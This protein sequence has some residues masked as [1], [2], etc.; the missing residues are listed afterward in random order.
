[1]VF[2]DVLDSQSFVCTEKVSD[3]IKVASD[4]AVDELIK[5]QTIQSLNLILRNYKSL[6]LASGVTEI[7]AVASAEYSMAKNQ[8]SFFEELFNT[9]GFRFKILTDEEQLNYLYLSFIN[10]LDAPKGLIVSINGT[11]TQLLAY[12]RR[13]IVNQSVI[14]LGTVA[15]A[16]EKFNAGISTE[17]FM[18]TVVN[19]Y[20]SKLK[21]INWFADMDSETQIVGTGDS[22]L[23]LARL[24]Q[25]V[26]HYTYNREHNYTLSKEDFGSV[27]EFVKTLEI[28]RNKKLKGISNERADILASNISAI[29]A[30]VDASKIDSI[31]I[32]ENGVAEGV[33]FSKACPSTIEKPI[34]DVL[35][36][37]L[38]TINEYYNNSNIKNTKNVYELSLILF[39]QL[40]VLHKLPRTFVKVLRTASY[41][42]DCGKRIS[43]A[44]YERKG[45]NIVL[46]SD[47]YGINHREQILS[48]FVVASQSL[49]KFSMTDWVKYKDMFTDADLVGV[50]KLAVIVKLATALDCFG[51]GKIKDISCDIL[52]DSVIMKTVVES[53]A[54]AEIKEGLKVA[55]DFAKAF[56]KHLEIL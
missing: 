34:T 23:S 40:K 26:K 37:S 48:A 29:K 2:A 43:V 6:C 41:M 54:D 39:K 11:T 55:G 45:F 51:S 8:R 50:R 47:I 1:M 19:D 31:V 22:F 15:L 13:N 46:G 7:Y 21:K 38:D 56:K 27:Y 10:S 12:N 28:D 35:G 4:L 24:S 52:G 30:V 16:D 42:H 49:E 20:A 18:Q 53:P 32:S 14:S 17:K 3:L 44:D 9:S 25:K 36:Y 33:L 5:Q